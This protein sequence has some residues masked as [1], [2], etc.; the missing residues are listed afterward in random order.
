MSKKRKGGFF[1]R[2]IWTI[3]I[4]GFF[5][6]GMILFLTTLPTVGVLINYSTT[7]DLL[8]TEIVISFSLGLKGF[9]ALFGGELDEFAVSGKITSGDSG[10]E[11]PDSAYP[12]LG[13]DLSFNYVVLIGLIL[14]VIGI[15]V[16]AVLFFRKKQFS[17]LSALLI[18][19]GAI[20]LCLDSVLF[21]SINSEALGFLKDV[22]GLTV[23]D[24]PSLLLGILSALSGITVFFHA[25][26]IKK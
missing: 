15:V 20:L 8:L 19:A 14:V 7:I 17:L 6:L 25:L 16:L 5:A 23:I 4:V 11:I 9:G 1:S 13:S 22:E 21:T 10:F 26:T 2:L 12:S 3:F 24:V 18:V